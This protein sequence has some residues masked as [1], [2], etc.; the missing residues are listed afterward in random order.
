[1]I[2]YFDAAGRK[3]EYDNL[4]DYEKGF[5]DGMF[6]IADKVENEYR[7][8]TADALAE[9]I[10]E[11][12]DENKDCPPPNCDSLEKCAEI[13]TYDFLMYYEEMVMDLLTRNYIVLI[14]SFMGIRLPDDPYN[15]F[16]GEDFKKIEDEY[17]K[18]LMFYNSSRPKLYP[19]LNEYGRGMIDA[20]AY[21]L[22]DLDMNIRT[23]LETEAGVEG[24]R[25]EIFD[26][27]NGNVNIPIEPGVP[28]FLPVL[29][30]IYQIFLS[31]DLME[32]CIDHIVDRFSDEYMYYVSK[33]TNTDYDEVYDTVMSE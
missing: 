20:Y 9:Y 2:N 5:L 32:C 19:I 3:E 17:A 10:D 12:I 7:G 22:A 28:I 29:E 8:L 14:C 33:Y 23:N 4:S 13:F 11:Y 24:V 27:L 26:V 16:T 30:A 21:V 6:N 15:F 1:M 31:N 18:G 25:A